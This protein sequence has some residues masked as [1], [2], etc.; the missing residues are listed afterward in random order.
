MEVGFERR[1]GFLAW[2]SFRCP[3]LVGTV[4]FGYM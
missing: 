4:L 1:V 3:V 2:H